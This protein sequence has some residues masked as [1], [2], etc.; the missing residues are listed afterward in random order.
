MRMVARM[1]TVNVTTV[2]VAV[3][4][5]QGCDNSQHEEASGKEPSGAAPTAPSVS[6]PDKPFGFTPPPQPEDPTERDR[7]LAVYEANPDAA[8]RLGDMYRDGVGESK[9]RGLAV[10]WYSIAKENGSPEADSRLDQMKSYMDVVAKEGAEAAERLR[11]REES[12]WVY[13]T[14]DDELTGKQVKMASVKS[15]E[16]TLSSPFDGSQRATLTVRKHPRWGT[17]IQLRIERGVFSCLGVDC[18]ILARFD[19]GSILTFGASGAESGSPTL[20]FFDNPSRFLTLLKK[21]KTT[22]LAVNVLNNGEQTFEFETIWL[23][24]GEKAKPASASTPA[25]SATTLTTPRKVTKQEGSNPYTSYSSCV[26][27][28]N[29]T[30]K[31]AKY[32]PEYSTN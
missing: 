14:T 23:E 16:F 2:L 11:R 24:W 25:V 30:E 10:Y 19:G 7:R 29:S 32:F 27:L 4:M 12:Q 28:G 13:Q 26:R 18:Q 5:C 20:L 8:I 31:C 6:A 21:S 3:L 9:D 1:N 15:N 17:D 22:Q